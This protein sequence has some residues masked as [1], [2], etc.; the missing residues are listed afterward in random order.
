M[1][2]VSEQDGVLAFR[3]DPAACA[4]EVAPV[5]V[6]DL[7]AACRDANERMTPLSA[8]VLRGSADTFFVQRPRGAAEH[9][10]IAVAWATATATVARLAAPTIAVLR[11]DVTGPGLELALSCDLRVAASDARLGSPELS[12]GRIPS[13]GGTQRITRH[14]GSAIALRLLLSGDI[15]SGRDA[16]LLG[17]VHG[18]VPESELESCLGSILQRMCASAPIALAYGK[19]AALRASDLTLTEGMRFEADLAAL[20][21]TTSDRAE[22]IGAF[23]QKRRAAFSGR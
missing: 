7:L 3:V 1:L 11:G 8:V 21:H 14:S 15:L 19:E 6:P 10:A 13:A 20:L 23:L 12:W 22:G 2:D 4:S 16:C 17:L 5:L 18:T 9:D